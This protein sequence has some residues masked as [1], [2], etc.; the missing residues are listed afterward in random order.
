VLGGEEVEPAELVE[1]D[2]VLAG[3]C[4]EE[5]FVEVLLVLLDIEED[6]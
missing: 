3:D 1:D 4:E 2:D 5:D 6:P